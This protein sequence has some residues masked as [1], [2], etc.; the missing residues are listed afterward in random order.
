VWTAAAG[1]LLGAAVAV[2]YANAVQGRIEPAQVLLAGYFGTSLLLLLKGFD[3]A[4]EWG[5]ALL[6]GLRP[7]DHAALSR[8]NRG[9]LVL[10]LRVVLLFAVGLPWVMAAVMTYR[11]RT[12]PADD[13]MTQLGLAFEPVRFESVDGV[14]LSGW[15][16][17]SQD[18]RGPTESDRTVVVCHGLGANKSN[19]LVLAGHFA[20]HGFNVLIFD[21]RAHGQSR[22]QVSGFGTREWQDV[23]GAVRWL[24]Q[25]RPEQARRIYGVGAS[26]GSVALLAA[27]AQGGPES[28]A[29]D[30]IA[31]YAPYDDLGMLAASVAE[32]WF[33]T[34]LDWLVQY[35]AVPFAS[36][37]VGENL[38]RFRPADLVVQVWPRPVMVIH[39]QDDAVIPYVH[40]LRLFNSALQPKHRIWLD[41]G[42]DEIL[43]EEWTAEQVRWFFERI[44]A[45]PVL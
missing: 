10:V 6:V 41:G 28:E 26:M 32:L 22:G 11:P 35:M 24:Q 36:V 17:P 18:R 31:L 16:I 9:Q 43:H 2:V 29:I 45:T 30:A 8:S 12:S 44:R 21:M 14:P 3:R 20:P 40:G 25:A 19:H 4:L 27:A 33:P 5:L 39:G 7:G 23:L 38:S 13:P 15:W 1:L 42:H 37:H 34:P